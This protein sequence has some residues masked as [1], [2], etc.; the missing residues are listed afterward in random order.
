MIAEEMTK[1]LNSTNYCIW[2]SL[3]VSGQQNLIT[4]QFMAYKKN[5][6]T[7]ALNGIQLSI[8]T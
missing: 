1:Q 2:F 8:Q 6:G 3:Q 4:V 5:L 7:N